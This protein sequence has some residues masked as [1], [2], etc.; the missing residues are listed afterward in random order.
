MDVRAAKTEALNA[1]AAAVGRLAE[2]AGAELEEVSL[3]PPVPLSS[4]VQEALREA[5]L[6]EGVPALAFGSG[7]GHDAGILAAA[8]VEAGMLFVRSRNGGVSHRPEELSDRD[9]IVAAVAVLTG[10]LRSLCGSIA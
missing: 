3:D 7:A 6:A 2:A 5:A 8:G 4:V 1:I 9:D 10:A